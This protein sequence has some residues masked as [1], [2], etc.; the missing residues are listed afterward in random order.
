MKTFS[1]L[2]LLLL[3]FSL[4]LQ[5]QSYKARWGEDL[6]A[7]RGAFSINSLIG[8]TNEAYH[9]FSSG[10]KGRTLQSYSWN[11]RLVNSQPISFDIKNEDQLELDRFIHTQNYTYGVFTLKDRKRQIQHTYVSQFTADSLSSLNRIYVEQYEDADLYGY[12]RV[13]GLQVPQFDRTVTSPDSSLLAFASQSFNQAEEEAL[14]INIIA[15]NENFS[16][17]WES[18]LDF[19][20]KR[21]EAS[22]AQLA[23]NNQ[24]EVYAL[25]VVDNRIG[26]PTS[27]GAFLKYRY[28][29]LKLS[30]DTIQGLDFEL[31]DTTTIQYAD[32]HLPTG[33][34]RGLILAGMYTDLDSRGNLKGAFHL[35]IDDN[36][37]VVSKTTT[38]FSAELIRGLRDNSAAD[39]SFGLDERFAIQEL[40]TLSTGELGLIAEETYTSEEPRLIEPGTKT[41]YHSDKLLIILF[42]PRG[43]IFKE[44]YV[45]KD[46]A[47]TN[48]AA[49][50]FVSQVVDDQLVLVFNDD[51][52]RAERTQLQLYGRYSAIPTDL[53]VLNKYL[54]ITEQ[55]LL[56]TNESIGSK[57]F[58]PRAS[59]NTEEGILLYTR[60]DKDL[61][62]GFLRL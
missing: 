34:G 16:I 22:L 48:L 28:E 29:L 19:P 62:C 17:L 7:P 52:T 44:A 26:E 46:Y 3:L 51:K 13:A 58:L 15:Y 56:F 27:T 25:M 37:S 4:T 9:V 45:D 11:H 20:Y 18:I 6:K 24:G 38:P 23:I 39:Q 54:R 32:L 12:T 50:S 41:L 36:F 14:S 42:S 8:T 57:F 53:V 21:N 10:K 47:S 31:S 1:L 33:N 61:Q 59:F 30:T 60:K 49:T 2:P 43:E 35:R 5:A 40:F 55:K